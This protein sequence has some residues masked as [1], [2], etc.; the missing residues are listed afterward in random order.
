[1]AATLLAVAMLPGLTLAADTRTLWIGAPEL[2]VVD[3]DGV[4]VNNGKLFPTPVTVPGAGLDPH[5]TFFAVQILSTDNQNLAH[6]VL[7]INAGTNAGLTLNTFFDPD[8]GTD[9]DPEFCEADGNVITCDYGSLAASNPERTVAVIVD[10]D[11]SYVALNQLQPVFSADVIT[12][13]EN[14]A[15]QQH[16][17]ASSG[18]WAGDPE[19]GF[20]VGAFSANG[21]N[22]FVPPGQAKQFFTSALG[23]EGAGNLSTTIN[24]TTTGAEL[25]AINEGTTV[26]GG[27][28]QCPTGLTCQSDYSEVITTSGSFEASP[29]FVWKLTALVPKTYSLAKGFVAHYED[30]ATSPDWTLLFK[31]KSSFCG[32]LEITEN[33]HCIRTLTL[34]RSVA[35]FSTL[36]V[37]VVMDEQGG[38]KY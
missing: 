13:N 32:D 11:S 10:V 8:G 24:F 37:E 20:A 6:T 14:G 7:T 5:A 22:T 33:G 12:N 26:P 19:P 16:F 29:Y 9:A 30:G 3:G 1:M 31:S 18:P 2:S 27:P 23:A 17:T 15:N 25:L 4:P 35:G 28:Y 36:V 21:L 38:M 34:S